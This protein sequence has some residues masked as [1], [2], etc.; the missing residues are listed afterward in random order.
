[1]QYIRVSHDTEALSLLK[2]LTHRWGLKVPNLVISVTGGAKS[3]QL[4]PRLKEAFSKGLI[5]VAV[6]TDAWIITGKGHQ[7][8]YY[9]LYLKV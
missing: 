8:R 9:M 2:L 1:M 4:S 6:S 5:K 7:A 3:F